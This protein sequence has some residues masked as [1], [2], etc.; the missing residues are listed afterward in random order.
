VTGPAGGGGRVLVA[1]AR[2]G[3]GAACVELLARGGT[4]VVGVDRADAA[5]AGPGGGPGGG[6]GSGGASGGPGGGPDRDEPTPGGAARPEVHAVDITVPGGA[7][8]AVELAEATLGG[9]DGI[10]H[11]VGMS[12]R[13]LGDGPVTRCTDGAWAEVLRVNLESAMRLLR[14]GLPALERAGGGAFV[15][16]GSVLAGTADRDFLTAAYAASKGGLAS[17]VRAAAMEVAA[18]GIRVNLVAAGLVD[19]PMASR[20]LLDE[21]IA[22]RLPQLQPLG[23]RAVT[24]AEVA[25]AV[26]FLLS[27]ASGRT[28]GAVLPVDGGWLLR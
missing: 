22:R 25:A 1:G 2:G 21:Q 11:A 24:A 7:E 3:I 27:P 15:A 17:L 26:A 14:A 9:L 8:R 16:I 19:T 23:G 6:A 4:P 28:T 13:R 18:E 20:A 12:G 5:S 10:V